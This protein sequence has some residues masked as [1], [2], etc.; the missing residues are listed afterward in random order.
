LVIAVPITIIHSINKQ[1]Q[2]RVNL[3]GGCRGV[4]RPPPR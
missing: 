1:D 2:S 3:V 4:H